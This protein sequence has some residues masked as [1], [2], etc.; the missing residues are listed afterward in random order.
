M[1]GSKL[2]VQAMHQLLRGF[3]IVLIHVLY[4]SQYPVQAAREETTDVNVSRAKEDAANLY[5]VSSIGC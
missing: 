1:V 4:Q 5:L 3:E 2:P